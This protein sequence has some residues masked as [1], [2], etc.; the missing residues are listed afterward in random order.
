MSD[1]LGAGIV[2]GKSGFIARNILDS[3]KEKSTEVWVCSTSCQSDFKNK[4][5]SYS[6]FLEN[7]ELTKQFP[8]RFDFVCFAQ[9][10]NTNDSIYN[11][12]EDVFNKI[13]DV[14]CKFILLSINRLLSFNNLINDSK[15]CIVSSIWQELARNEKLSYSISKSALRGLVLSLVADLAIKGCR[16]NA[17]LPGP[18]ESDM[19]K[20]NLTESQLMFFIENSPYKRLSS[21]QEV[22]NSMLWLLSDDSAGVTGNFLK[23]NQGFGDVVVI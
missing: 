18:I 20:S 11:F 6:D 17:V 4:I 15:I 5:I 2:F 21:I 12:R 1:D 8:N 19:T 23:I 16:I 3:L 13:L 14:N 22:I 9:G 10:V 7:K